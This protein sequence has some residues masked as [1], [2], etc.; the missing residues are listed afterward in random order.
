MIPL[1]AAHHT[2]R[3]HIMKLMNERLKPKAG[4]PLI[5]AL[6]GGSGSGKTSLGALLAKDKNITVVELDDFF[7]AH[8]TDQQWQHLDTQSK[9][10]QVFQWQRVRSELLEPLMSNQ[11]AQ[12][13]SVNW[14]SGS[15]PD[16]SFQLFEELKA[17][18]PNHC[19]ILEGT[20]SASPALSDLI[21]LAILLDV[22]TPERHRRLKA[23]IKTYDLSLWHQR[24]DAVENYYFQCV[25]PKS[26]FDLILSNEHS[27]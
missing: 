24:W 8:L 22:S 20:Y 6:D 15:N 7:S 9:L 25:K 3:L 5:V 18:T 21:D 19:I 17:A 14:S 12:W 4:Q 2:A 26:K 13:R 23:R 27:N 11:I 16:G 10:E 1:K